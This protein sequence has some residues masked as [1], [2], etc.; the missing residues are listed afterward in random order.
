MLKEALVAAQEA[1]SAGMQVGETEFKD[2]AVRL[3]E[4]AAVCA[5]SRKKDVT[6]QTCGREVGCGTYIWN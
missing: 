5:D 4:C 2:C 6:P 3:V 1:E